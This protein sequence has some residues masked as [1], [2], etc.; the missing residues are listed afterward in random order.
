VEGRRHIGSIPSLM[1]RAS[2]LRIDA[3]TAEVLSRFA[4]VGVDALLLKGPAI[5][6]W[7]YNE[8]EPR[9]YLDC[10]LLIAPPHISAAE[11][12]LGDLGYARPFDDRRMPMWWQTHDNQWLR[13]RDGLTV[14]VHRALPGVGV[15]AEAAW[16]LLSAHTDVVMVAGYPAPTLALP[17]RALHVALHA[18]HHGADYRRPMS[19]LQRALLA[20]DDDLWRGAAAL[21]ARL[22]AMEILAAGLRLTPSGAQLAT[23]LGLPVTRSVD[24]ELSAGS[25]PPVGLAFEQLARADGM[26]ARTEIVWRKLVPPADFIRL[27]DP[28]AAHSRPSLLRAYLRR[29]AWI[30]R[31]APRGLEAWLRARRTVRS[32]RR[33][34]GS[35]TCDRLT[36]AIL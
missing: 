23:R 27:W 9:T 26:R 20:G 29:P 11:E 15:D 12:L 6:H 22:Q 10:D 36:A 2:A 14:D 13:D 1:A 24:V 21:A 31:H 25:P 8:G 5:A 34:T 33:V 30:L 17:A 16:T 19:D 7:L 28:R 35:D 18:A 3:G 32:S 4:E